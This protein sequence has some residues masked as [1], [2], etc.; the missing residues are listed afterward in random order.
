[1]TFDTLSLLPTPGVSNL[2]DIGPVVSELGRAGLQV[3]DRISAGEWVLVPTLTGSV[4]HEFADPIPSVF[5]ST[6]TT[7]TFTNTT[8]ES[9]IGTFGQISLGLTGQPVKN[10]NIT[11][12]FHADYRS[13]DNITG[14]T[15]TGAVRYQF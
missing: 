14:S 13:G 5:T 10:P 8:A 6:F 12:N 1:V 9:R 2:L 4:W 7:P 3:G 11:V 15:F